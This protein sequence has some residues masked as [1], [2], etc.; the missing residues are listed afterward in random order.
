[1]SL[2]QSRGV[3]WLPRSVEDRIARDAERTK[4]IINA[5]QERVDGTWPTLI[6]ATSVRALAG[7][8]LRCSPRWGLEARAVSGSTEISVRRRVV[9]EFRSG[10]IKVL[11]NYGVFQEGLTPPKPGNNRCAPGVQPQPVFPNDW[12]RVARCEEWRQ[13][14]VPGPECEG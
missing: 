13:R 8:L 4:R 11:V 10:E 9:E 12:Q 2:Q 6:F 5:Y 14:P 3:P 1:M 7:L